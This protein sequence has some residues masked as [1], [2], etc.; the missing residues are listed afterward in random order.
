MLA[1]LSLLKIFYVVESDLWKTLIS[2]A[3]TQTEASTNEKPCVD[4]STKCEKF[5]KYCESN[6]Y[7]SKRCEKTCG[8]CSKLLRWQFYYLQKSLNLE[9]SLTKLDT[10]F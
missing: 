7:V 3:A 9:W 5:K 10:F 1:I 8:K 4:I 2:V 6:S